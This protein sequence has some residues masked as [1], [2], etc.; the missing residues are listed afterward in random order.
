ME[1]RLSANSN[2]VKDLVEHTERS[3]RSEIVGE[4]MPI[5]WRRKSDAVN[6]ISKSVLAALMEFNRMHANLP[7]WQVDLFNK[8]IPIRVRIFPRDLIKTFWRFDGIWQRNT[9]VL[10]SL[11]SFLFLYFFFFLNSFSRSI[12]I[13]LNAHALSR[14]CPRSCTVHFTIFFIRHRIIQFNAIVCLLH[15]A[16]WSLA[17]FCGAC[18]KSLLHI[19]SILSIHWREIWWC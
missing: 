8:K 7:E 12:H 5:E 6:K 14:Y 18:T 19:C 17:C 3:T 16:V 15:F 1:Q 10:D 4:G 13:F 9:K 2:V 11:S